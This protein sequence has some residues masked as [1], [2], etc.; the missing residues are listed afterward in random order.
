MASS[1]L[2]RGVTFFDTAQIYGPAGRRMASTA[3]HEVLPTL[4]CSSAGG[5]SLEEKEKP[6]RASNTK[7]GNQ[8]EI[9][10]WVELN[11][12][13]HAYQTAPVCWLA[14][15]SVDFTGFRSISC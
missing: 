7:R 11:Y 3:E 8:F 9:W 1:R 4:E 13:P 15:T 14:M 5:G 6:R 12:R 2:E 10:A